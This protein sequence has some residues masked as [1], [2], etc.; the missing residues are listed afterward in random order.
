MCSVAVTTNTL[1]FTA[2]IN[3]SKTVLSH[4]QNN[5]LF[6]TK[7]QLPGGKRHKAVSLEKFE[8]FSKTIAVIACLLMVETVQWEE[9]GERRIRFSWLNAPSYPVLSPHPNCHSKDCNTGFTL[10]SPFNM[11]LS[12]YIPEGKGWFLVNLLTV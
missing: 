1:W 7:P 8:S 6:L 12:T 4:L 3:I 5:A 10:T 9:G 2:S 11:L